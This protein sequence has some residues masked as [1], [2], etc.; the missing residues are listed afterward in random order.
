MTAH[1]KG[2]NESSK[3]LSVCPKAA[4]VALTLSVCVCMCPPSYPVYAHSGSKWWFCCQTAPERLSKITLQHNVSCN[5]NTGNCWTSAGGAAT[6]TT[7]I[8]NSHSSSKQQRQYSV[9]VCVR[10]QAGDSREK[11]FLL[12]TVLILT[13]MDPLPAGF[14]LAKISGLW[15]FLLDTI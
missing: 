1:H 4:C 15:S 8:N 6:A 7:V 13:I 9:C 12:K 2:E 3:C 11:E 14:P 10:R 5:K